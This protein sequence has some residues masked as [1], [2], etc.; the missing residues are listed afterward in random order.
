LDGRR[1]T[2]FPVITVNWGVLYVM[3]C[4]DLTTADRFSGIGFGERRGGGDRMI[5]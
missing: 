3:W 1:T 4:G 5:I 2:L